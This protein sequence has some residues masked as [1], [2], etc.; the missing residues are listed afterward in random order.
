MKNSKIEWTNHTFNSWIGCSHIST[1]CANCYAETLMDTRYG[2][3]QWGDHGTRVRTSESYW[4]Q[5]FKWD[6]Q[7]EKEGG[8]KTVFC[9]SLADIFE[10]RDDLID[11]RLDLFEHVI[12]KT[13]NL[14][15]LILTKRID[16]AAHFLSL[17]KVP[18]NVWLG[19][20]IC[21]QKESDD[22]L[23][24]LT[25]LK[26]KVGGTFISFEPLL[27]P[28]KISSISVDWAIIG[29]KASVRVE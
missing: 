11:W 23:P 27:E 25:R 20:S 6:R 15:W 22:V 8:V 14:T 3:V 26:G 13:P 19:H 16:V 29:G 17:V 5:P 7:A 9:A 2:R 10:D 4:K 28:I 18:S 24:K 21:T 12:K 1:G